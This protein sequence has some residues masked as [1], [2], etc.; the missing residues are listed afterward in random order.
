MK[1]SRICLLL[2][3]ACMLTGLI[4]VV[5]CDRTSV[6]PTENGPELR[7]RPYSVDGIRVNGTE[8]DD[9]HPPGP[10]FEA[11]FRGSKING[12]SPKGNFWTRHE[13]DVA[14]NRAKA[15]IR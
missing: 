10:T 1:P 11:W 14:L 15:G 12:P 2:A 7:D 9:A 3:V 5:S 6:S 13:A 4:A 8:S